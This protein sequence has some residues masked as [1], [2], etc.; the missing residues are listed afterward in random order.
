[1]MSFYRENNQC[2]QKMSLFKVENMQRQYIFF[3]YRIDL[4]FYD[5]KLGIQIDKNNHSDRN[6]D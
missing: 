5:Y 1:M 2:W 3:G 6:I 4:H